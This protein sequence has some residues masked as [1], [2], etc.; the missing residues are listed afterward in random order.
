MKNKDMKKEN[1]F[2]SKEYLEKLNKYWNAANYLSAA[3]LYLLDNPLL[4]DHKLCMAD[5]KKKLVGPGELFR[6]KIL[7]MLIAIE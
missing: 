3:Q 2:L 1:D 6:D 4:R 7:C 5:I